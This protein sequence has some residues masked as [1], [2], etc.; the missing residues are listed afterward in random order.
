M[1]GF[2]NAQGHIDTYLYILKKSCKYVAQKRRQFW[3]KYGKNYGI[4]SNFLSI[5][6]KWL[7]WFNHLTSL[8]Y[9]SFVLLMLHVDK[10]VDQINNAQLI[11]KQ[12]ETEQQ[13]AL[14]IQLTTY[15][16]DILQTSYK[17]ELNI[18]TRQK[19]K[20]SAFYCSSPFLSLSFSPQR[21]VTYCQVW[22]IPDPAIFI[23]DVQSFKGAR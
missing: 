15:I 4:W 9:H 3:N 5:Q 20:M 8:I 21:K 13:L 12:E 23:I 10:L 16:R 2:F 11:T 7:S 18:A 19:N 1:L 22:S 6:L 17:K 14:W